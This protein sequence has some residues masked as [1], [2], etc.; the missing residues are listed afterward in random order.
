MNRARVGLVRRG[1]DRRKNVFNAMDLVRD[2][3]IPK[4]GKEVMLKPNFLSSSNQLASTHPDAIRGAIDFLLSCPD[5][6]DKILVAEGGNEKQSGEAFDNFGYR[7]IP[8]E[9][10]I[11]IEL[12]DLNQETAW[13]T[14]EIY[15]GDRSAYTVY[16]P[17]S[18]LEC[19]CTISVAVAKT[20]NVCCVTLSVKNMIV[21]TI[22][23]QDRG[24]M[25]GNPGVDNFDASDEARCLNINL[26]RLAR[27]L[28]P[29]IGVVDGTVGL[30]GNGPGGTDGIPFG[31]AGA[32][33]DHFAV[34]AVMA[35]AMGFEPMELGLLSYANDLGMGTADLD[36]ID[37]AGESIASL[38]RRF[39]PHETNALQ[40]QWHDEEAD[41][42]LS[43]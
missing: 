23:K 1:D 24:K 3:L 8:D 34:D 36:H 22:R 21:G 16:M 40:L 4:I 37:V 28:T 7:A 6:P 18:V 20:H 38:L 10:D 42:Y 33:S 25:H 35:K 11:P 19:P 14:I 17:Q 31:S 2:D 39:K 41:R 32:S 5:R 27:H 15:L 30:Q 13:E 29:T 9:F 12:I 43:V 26:I